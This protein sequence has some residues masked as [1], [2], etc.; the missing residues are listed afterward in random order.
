MNPPSEEAVGGA[1]GET[2]IYKLHAGERVLT[3]GDTARSSSEQSTVI[4]NVFNLAATINNDLDIRELAD[5]LADL[6]EVELR[7]RVSYV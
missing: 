4:N 3:A 6:Q 2:G 7:R 1:I 5:K